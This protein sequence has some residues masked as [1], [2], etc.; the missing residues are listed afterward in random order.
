LIGADHTGQS[1]ESYTYNANGNRT[2]SGYDIDPNNQLASDG[3][4]N[5]TYDDEGNRA[6]KTNISSGEKE[7]YSW[8]HR[9]RLTTVTFKNSGGTVTKT[10]DHVY[11]AFNRWIRRTID[12]DGETGSAAVIDTIFSHENGQIA[13]EFD[14]S[15]ASDLTHRYTWGELVDQLFADESVSSLTSAGTMLWALPD[16]LGTPRDLAT[17]NASTDDTAIANHRRHDSYG[18]LISETDTGVN[19]LFGFTG[20]PFD[21][22]T[23]LNNHWHRWFAFNVWPNED[24][25]GFSAADSNLARYSQNAPTARIDPDGLDD[26]PMFS[27]VPN[28]LV[29]YGV[30]DD[31]LPALYAAITN[32]FEA[33]AALAKAEENYDTTDFNTSWLLLVFSE[34]SRSPW[35]EKAFADRACARK[36][37]RQAL[38]D[39]KKAFPAGGGIIYQIN[40]TGHLLTYDVSGSDPERVLEGLALAG[41]AFGGLGSTG[42]EQLLLLGPQL[43]VIGLKAVTAKGATAAIR[44]SGNIIANNAKGKAFEQELKAAMCKTHTEVA[45]Q[46]TVKTK[47]GTKTILDLIGKEKNTGTVVIQEAKS[48]A[49]APL[50]KAQKAAFPEIE[51]SGAVVVG[52]GKPGFPGGTIIPP[53]PVVITRP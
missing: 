43:V 10:V 50:T 30:P 19:V 9:N 18:I 40:D 27:G 1:D 14:G 28:P 16:H 7:E 44:P 35:M 4:F 20:R 34:S 36:A 17:Y 47:T 53:T 23:G 37:Y 49:T 51:S 8:D 45:E 46:V 29:I 6:T 31:Q 41:K 26:H 39:L 3:T 12:P 24:L 42:D 22:S 38:I 5:Y 25:I 2:M 32:A 33:Q 52:K 13:L 11:D 21:E 15:A 48:S